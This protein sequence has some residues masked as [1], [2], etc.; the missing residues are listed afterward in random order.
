MKEAYFRP[1]ELTSHVCYCPQKDQCMQFN[2][3]SI[4]TGH[5]SKEHLTGHFVKMDSQS[6]T[7]QQSQDYLVPSAKQMN[8]PSYR[9]KR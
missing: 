1:E 6:N 9:C 3:I 2:N 8:C 4:L 5:L 7:V